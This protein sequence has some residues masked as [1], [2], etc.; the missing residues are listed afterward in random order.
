MFCDEG[1]K[2]FLQEAAVEISFAGDDEHYPAQQI[3]D[4]TIINA[5]TGNHLIGDVGNRR[6]LGWDRK[7]G[8]FE[9]LPGAENVVDPP[10]LTVVFE[11]ADAEFDDLIAIEVRGGGFHIHDSGD[12]LG[13]L[14]GAWYSACGSRR[15]VTR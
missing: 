11:E 3:V 10:V 8:I 4:G 15:Q 12:D 6:D 14:S 1:W 5:V 2:S 13:P 7:T 9:P